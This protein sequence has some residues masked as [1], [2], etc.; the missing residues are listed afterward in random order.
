MAYKESK[1][2]VCCC[3]Q[4]WPLCAMLPMLGLV[5]LDCMYSAMC[6]V[7]THGEEELQ[8]NG[9][10]FCITVWNLQPCGAESS[11]G[12]NHRSVIR[13]QQNRAKQTDPGPGLREY[14]QVIAYK[15]VYEEVAEYIF[16]QSKIN[17]YIIGRCHCTFLR[18]K[19]PPS[20]LYQLPLL[21]FKGMNFDHGF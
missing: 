18:A 19:K 15:F 17:W 9:E 1:Q 20:P 5:C 12:K 8:S 7:V 11:S 2:V 4:E 10:N 21:T 3:S 13:F 14:M 6:R 16:L